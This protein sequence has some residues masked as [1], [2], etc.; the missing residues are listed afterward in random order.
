MQAGRLRNQIVI[1]SVAE[2]RTGTGAVT[3]VW[4]TFATVWAEKREMRGRE[5]FAADARQDE[6]TAVFVI[7]YF[8]GILPKMRVSFNGKVYDIKGVT[9]PD[10][11]TR[12]INLLCVQGVNNG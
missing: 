9:D 3:L 11:R 2:T 8:P 1:E 7:R 12:E 4:S 10:D 6:L 5:F